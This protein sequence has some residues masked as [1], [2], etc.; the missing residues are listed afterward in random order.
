MANGFNT[1]QGFMLCVFVLF[2]ASVNV[3]E[4]Q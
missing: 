1:R 4:K 3:Q 2:L